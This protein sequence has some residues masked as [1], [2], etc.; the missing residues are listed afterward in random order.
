MSE[1]I[2]GSRFLEAKLSR[3]TVLKAGV[4][5]GAAAVLGRHLLWPEGTTAQAAKTLN[6][7]T[8]EGYAPTSIIQKFEKQTGFKA[9]VTFYASNGELISKLRATKATGFDLV[10]PSVT[11]IPAALD[12]GL[13]QPIDE[14]K[15]SNFR[16]VIPSMVKASEELG[17]MSKGKRYGLP[18]DWGTEG[19]SYNTKRVAKRPKSFGA[20]HQDEF[21]GRVTYRATFHV[22]VS[23]G[24]WMGLGN[25]MRDVYVSEAKARPILDKILAFLISKK[26]NVK[27]YWSTAA[28]IEK[29]LSTEEVWIAETWDGTGWKLDRAGN[30]IKFT[31]PNEGAMTWMDGFAIPKGAK[32]LDAAYAWINFMY[33]PRNSATFTKESAYFTAVE[34]AAAHL[35][36]AIKK[37]YEASFSPKDIRNLWWYGI[38]HTWWLDMFAGYVDRLK[39]A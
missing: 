21:A 38:E 35:E 20:V 4:A 10:Q 37:Q 32:N 31:A 36:P 19:I 39:A 22:F 25:R 15:I 26:K 18:F 7:F 33:D 13:Y 14:K 34:G 29:L 6:L 8:W 23:T 30:P 12:F 1:S 9:K 16:N 27:T 11:L 5:A 24:L 17:G 3:R 28:E 2:Y